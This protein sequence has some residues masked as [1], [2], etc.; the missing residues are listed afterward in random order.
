MAA[1]Y[2]RKDYIDLVN[3]GYNPRILRD[4]TLDFPDGNSPTIDAAEELNIVKEEAILRI[5]E[6]T[7]KLIKNGF[8]FDSVVFSMSSNAQINWNTLAQAEHQNRTEAMIV[9][10]NMESKNLP[11]VT[12]T[13]GERSK[14]ITGSTDNTG[15]T[16]NNA[17]VI[18]YWSKSLD[19]GEATIAQDVVEKFVLPDRVRIGY[20]LSVST[21]DGG[22][23][24]FD[25]STTLLQ[26]AGVAMFHGQSLYDS[27]RALRLQVLAASSITEV[28]AIVDSRS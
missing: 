15:Y 24:T 14:T 2:T 22:E 25:D 20:P 10:Q 1:K 8:T 26:F 3:Q 16:I 13:V 19:A 18:A 27:G 23:Y 9:E 11:V 5:D 7:Q 28:E 4:G 6:K 17:L 12:V 21:K